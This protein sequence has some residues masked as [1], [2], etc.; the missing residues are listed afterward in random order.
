MPHLYRLCLFDFASC[1]YHAID[2]QQFL[3]H[4][5]LSIVE[6]SISLTSDDII[7]YNIDP[8]SPLHNIA[9]RT[10]TKNRSFAIVCD[11][12]H[13]ELPLTRILQFCLNQRVSHINLRFNQR[14][15]VFFSSFGIKVYNTLF[16]PDLSLYISNLDYTKR[17]S[18]HIVRDSR[19]LHSGSLSIH[20]LYRNSCIESIKNNSTILNRRFPNAFSMLDNFFLFSS[21][22]NVSLNLDFNRRIIE[23]GICGCNLIADSLED[24]QWLYPFNLFKPFIS[25][26]SSRDQLLTL[27]QNSPT[28]SINSGF[29]KLLLNFSNIRFDYNLRSLMLSSILNYAFL[30]MPPH[31]ECLLNDIHSYDLL[32]ESIRKGTIPSEYDFFKDL[33]GSICS[34]FSSSFSSLLSIGVRRWSNHA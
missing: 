3:L 30:S 16:S 2:I 13:G 18:P 34:E 6:S 28:N 14:H 12:H 7:V 10:P 31:L 5:L 4:G 23:A 20:H 9:S 19:V 8:F 33:S 27:I 26:F 32:Q 15:S 25:F 11:T 24:T 29:T 17:F 22:L 1:S 21:V